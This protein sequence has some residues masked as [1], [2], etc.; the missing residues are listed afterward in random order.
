[1]IIW[2]FIKYKKTSNRDGKKEQV[3]Q[4]LLF[5][6]DLGYLLIGQYRSSCFRKSQQV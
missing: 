5:S 6:F 2:L 3:P 4:Y 1:M